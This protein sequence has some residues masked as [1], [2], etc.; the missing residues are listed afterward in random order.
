SE[1]GKPLLIDFGT[2]NC[3]WCKQLDRTTFRDPAVVQILS[4]RFI[5]LKVDAEREANLTQALRIQNFPT[6]I[7]A[8]P[9]GKILGMIEGYQEAPRL[10]EHLNR[11]LNAVASPDWMARDL[12]DATRAAAASE[13]ARA[14]A[15]LKTIVED[16]KDRPVQVKARQL[17]QEL[18]QQASARLARVRQM[19][20]QGQTLEAADALTDLL[21]SYAGT[22]A[23][24]EG[25]KLLTA[26]AAKPEVRDRQRGQRARE[27]LAQARDD[28]RKELFFGC[29]EKCELLASTYAD[30][31][32]AVE[33]AQLSASVKDNPQRLA[34][35]CENLS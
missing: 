12:H 30:L 35:A 10:I 17:L 31:P 7:L 33:A 25:S 6:L 15:L 18:E 2:E 4:D 3:M 11:T 16:G 13:Y 32:E 14:V 5:L 29:I 24:S 20:D 22:Q 9:D 34:K 27:L 28:F 21:K 8:A 1:K 23:A 19:Q 26:L